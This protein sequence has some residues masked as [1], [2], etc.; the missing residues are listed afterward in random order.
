[1]L[2]DEF[3]RQHRS[4]PIERMMAILDELERN[5]AGMGLK[6]LAQNTGV[7]RS[8]VYRILNSLLAH[9]M[10]RQLENS[11]Y[12]LGRRLLS[13]ADNVTTSP[14]MGRIASTAYPHLESVSLTL[15]ETSKVS[16]YDRGSVLVVAYAAGRKP[17]ALHAQVGEHLPIHAGGASKVLLANLPEDEM[18]KHLARPL[19]RFTEFTLIEPDAL[20]EE[21]RKVR[22]QGWSRDHGEFNT[23]IKSYAAPIRD[24]RGEVAAA[25]S[26]PFLAGRD[27]EYEAL[28][29]RVAI[30]TANNIGESLAAQF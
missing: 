12:V 25:I 16:V 28:V 22:E 8:S 29:Q 26:I 6:R 15:G 27:E 14:H 20:R 23:S 1:V 24:H 18:N 17:Y 30:D 4:P 19:T 9:D 21:L 5:P 10:V 13:L 7:T 2:D 11:D 3:V